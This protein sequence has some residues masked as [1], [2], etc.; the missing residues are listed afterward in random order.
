MCV[1]KHG[2]NRVFGKIV[3]SRKSDSAFLC[4]VLFFK[5][6]IRFLPCPRLWSGSIIHITV[7]I[8]TV[9]VT[10]DTAFLVLTARMSLHL[11]KEPNARCWKTA[12][13]DFWRLL[14]V[15]FY[16]SPT[17]DYNWSW[18][19]WRIAARNDLYFHSTAPLSQQYFPRLT[20]ILSTRIRGQEIRILQET[21]TWRH[22]VA[23]IPWSR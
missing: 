18:V 17:S 11:T 2:G 14:C 3:L 9:A 13:L 6:A 4:T 23:L 12:Y 1:H 5:A 7:V 16:L 19:H 22:K 21:S 20:Q 10:W 8:L 15:G